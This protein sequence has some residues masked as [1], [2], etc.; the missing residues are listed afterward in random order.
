MKSFSFRVTSFM[1]GI[2][3]LLSACN[4]SSD[5]QSDAN[6]NT[7]STGGS[8]TGTSTAPVNTISTQPQ[9]MMVARHKVKDYDAWLKSYEANDSLRLAHGMHNYVISRGV[10]DP[11]TI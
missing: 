6:A 3:V 1:I 4:N 10:D 5:N 7:D 9:S 2:L 11:N 8:T